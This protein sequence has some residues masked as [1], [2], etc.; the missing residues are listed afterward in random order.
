MQQGTACLFL[1]YLLVKR[2]I[3]RHFCKQPSNKTEWH[4]YRIGIYHPLLGMK[5]FADWVEQSDI[6]WNGVENNVTQLIH[7]STEERSVLAVVSI[8]N[9]DVD[10]FVHKEN[11]RLLCMHTV[12]T[13]LSRSHGLLLGRA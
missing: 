2:E 6:F 12:Q 1:D 9:T 4:A 3:C 8:T 11:M 10:V 5:H 7:A 13:I